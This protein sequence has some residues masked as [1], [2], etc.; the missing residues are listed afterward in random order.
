MRSEESVSHYL[1]LVP[2]R[3]AFS[4]IILDAFENAN[5]ASNSS[6]MQ[7]VCSL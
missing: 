2:L 4:C 7:W 3:E 1:Q 6:V 5:P